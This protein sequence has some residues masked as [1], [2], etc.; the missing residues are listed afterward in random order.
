MSADKESKAFFTEE[1]KQK[2]F[3]LAV[4]ESSSARAQG[5]KSFLVLLFKKEPLGLPSTG[6]PSG[7]LV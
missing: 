1:K 4:A 5:N 7:F 6:Q 3:G 2:T